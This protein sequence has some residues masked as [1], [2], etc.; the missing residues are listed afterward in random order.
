MQ[1]M[2]PPSQPFLHTFHTPH[3]TYTDKTEHAD[4]AEGVDEEVEKNMQRML[5][6]PQLPHNPLV[7]QLSWWDNVHMTQHISNLLTHTNG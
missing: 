6:N 5:L 4:A 3:N 1:P 2:P 7:H